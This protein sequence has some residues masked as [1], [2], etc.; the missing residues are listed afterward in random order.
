MNT[1]I[2]LAWR[3]LWRNRRRTLITVASIF[4]GVMLSAY[5]TSMQEGSYTKMVDIVVKFY[6]GYMQVHHEDY[7]ENKSI[8]NSFEYNQE[9]AD[10]LLANKDVEFVFPRLESF[11]LASS[12]ELTKGAMIFGID[13]LGENQLTK[14]A[15]KVR[16]GKYLEAEDEGVL[17]GAG[18]AKYLQLGVNDTL[19][20]IS[21]GYHGVSAAEKFPVRGIIKHVSP[22]LNKTIV[23]MSLAKCQEFFS[24]ENRL[25]SLVINVADNDVMKRAFH[26]LK[27]KMKA[28]YSIMS[29]EEM[30]PEVV[31]QIESD[32][33]GGIIMKAILYIVIAFGILGTIMMMIMERRREFG[34][35]VAIG[36]RKGKLASVIFFETL[37]IGLLGILS[38]LLVSYPLLL[39]Q[40]ANPIP[41]TGQ[42]AQLME[43]FGFEPYMFFSTAWQVFS[44]QAI[45]VSVITL[46]IAIY[47]VI[48]IFRFKVIKALKA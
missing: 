12:K 1:N 6:S 46:I 33:A 21:Q 20:I 26:D 31:Q 42:A 4:F 39:L 43:E 47:P 44:Q 28:P 45:S 5:M 35:M 11:G 14:I 3:N 48:S 24:A 40:S 15:D 17:M 19:V 16:S 36:M 13:P 8:N 41:L 25:T 32:R 7:W 18:L 22:E 34:V 29:W 23:Y 37:F 10:E 2:K 38:G 30:Q 9:L 27:K